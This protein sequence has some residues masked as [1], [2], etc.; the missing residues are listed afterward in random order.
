[1]DR[2]AEEN[3][4][5]IFERFKGQYIAM[6][7]AQSDRTAPLWEE[8]DPAV[9]AFLFTAWST[10]LNDAATYANARGVHPVVIG[11]IRDIAACERHFEADEQRGRT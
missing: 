3:R 2:D 4:R 1:M 5:A 8:I 11:E 9:Q 6:R 10:G 7:N